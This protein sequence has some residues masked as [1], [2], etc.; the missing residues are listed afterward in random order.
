MKIITSKIKNDN[1]SD[2]TN[3]IQIISPFNK[4]T[5]GIEEINKKI[6]EKF[7]KNK[8][9]DEKLNANGYSFL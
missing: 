8:N 5:L 7:N 9:E 6:Q 1:D 3:Q 4:G 2:I